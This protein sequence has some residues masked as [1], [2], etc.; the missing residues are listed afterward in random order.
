[1]QLRTR[2]T[3][4]R[5]DEKAVNCWLS[6]PPTVALRSCGGEKVRHSLPPRLAVFPLTVPCAP[7]RGK[8]FRRQLNRGRLM[9]LSLE[10]M[11]EGKQKGKLLPIT[12]P[13]FLVGRDPQCHLRPASPSISKRHCVLI[14][15]EG[16]AF[17]R[18][19]DS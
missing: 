19:F 4:R 12:L 11:T 15:R 3:R 1:P 7:V 9:K 2:A 5:F 13:Q 8:A 16:R 6:C 17:I 18:D 14:Q 10:V